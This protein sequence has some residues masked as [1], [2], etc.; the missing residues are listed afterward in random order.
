MSLTCS[1]ERTIIPI[2]EPG[3]RE[4]WSMEKRGDSLRPA[5]MDSSLMRSWSSWRLPPSFTA[6]IMIFSVAMKGSSLMRCFS[7]PV[8]EENKELLGVKAEVT[9]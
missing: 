7:M 3:G 8:L 2:W 9:V 5:S 6:S 4:W 1:S